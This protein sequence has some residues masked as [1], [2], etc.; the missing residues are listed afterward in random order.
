MYDFTFGQGRKG[1][2]E[3]ITVKEV[4]E[5]VALES[6]TVAEFTTAAVAM[7][8]AV[9]GTVEAVN[10]KNTIICNYTTSRN[11][12]SSLSSGGNI[13]SRSGRSFNR[14]RNISNTGH[15]G[16]MCGK[17]AVNLDMSQDNVQP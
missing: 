6:G 13:S 7:K 11:S 4:K 5:P 16:N 8:V 9:S 15:G 2:V 17:D 12:S 14:S 3:A 10:S 1:I